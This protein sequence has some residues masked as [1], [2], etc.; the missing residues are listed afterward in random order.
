MRVL[1]ITDWNR[2]QGGAEAYIAWLRDGLR[3]AGDEVRLLTSSAG[4]AGNGAAEYI[5]YGTERVSAQTF[6]QIAN[7]FAV[8]RVRVALSEFRPDVVFV[9]M[10][11]HHLSPAILHAVKAFP[12]VLSVSDYK[13]VCP[14]GSKLLPD[15][16]VCTVRSGWICCQ[17]GCVSLPHW[18]RDRPRYALIRSGVAAMT[19][20][21]A[22]S[23]WVMKELA[24]ESITSECVHLPVPA[25]SADYR[26]VPARHPSF[27]FCGRLDVEKGVDKLLR[28]F[29]NVIA[30]HPGSRLSITGRGPERRRLEEL[31]GQLGI[32]DAVTFTG[33]LEPAAIEQELSRAWALVAPSLWAEPL[34]I[35][36]LEAIVR[37]V[38]VV[39]SATGGFAETIEEG[40]TGCLVPNGDVDMLTARMME[41]ASGARFTNHTISEAGIREAADRHDMGLH[42]ERMR[43][44]F[45]ETAQD[46]QSVL[47][48]QH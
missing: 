36:A 3:A 21:V 9:N 46:R 17:A 32:R 16:S 26:R 7:P 40:V 34:G 48:S 44:I 15:G 20:V 39:A 31:A 10:F 19:R 29:A 41:I 18:L 43:R 13:C 28:A 1:A 24:L 5:A 35:V 37:G 4:S 11:A 45:A 8:H 30:D 2:G 25:A 6:L 47:Q 42:I 23:E 27:L 38:P 22:C 14:I 33:W 12:T